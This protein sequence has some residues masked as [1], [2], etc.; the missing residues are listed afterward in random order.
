VRFSVKLT[1]SVPPGSAEKRW[2]VSTAAAVEDSARSPCFLL[3]IRQEMQS[4]PPLKRTESSFA[5]H[6]RPPRI[7]SHR[8]ARH[9]YCPRARRYTYWESPRARPPRSRS[10]VTMV[11]LTLHESHTAVCERPMIRVHCAREHR[12]A[13][14]IV[15]FRYSCFPSP[16]SCRSKVTVWVSP[17]S[18]VES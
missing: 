5:R 3:R 2:R 11:R 1:A 4:S 15:A 16:Q 10:G 14:Q 9:R 17:G 13:G 7:E 12:A 8:H 18:V 6:C